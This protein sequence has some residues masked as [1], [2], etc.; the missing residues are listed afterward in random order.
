MTKIII[1]AQSRPGLFKY[2]RSLYAHREL[3]LMLAYRDLR[4]RYSR[5]GLGLLWLIVQPGLSLLVFTLIFGRVLR[6]PTH[7]LPY[8]VFVYPGI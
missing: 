3:A 5:T 2:L 7:D 4:I 8:V 6:V 1:D